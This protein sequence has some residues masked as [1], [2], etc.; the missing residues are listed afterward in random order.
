[1]LTTCSAASREI[2]EDSE[3]SL[4][5]NEVVALGLEFTPLE[6][7]ALQSN[8]FNLLRLQQRFQISVGG[9]NL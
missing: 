6:A 4:F 9:Q 7:I 5:F 3:S 1:M 8:A 2:V